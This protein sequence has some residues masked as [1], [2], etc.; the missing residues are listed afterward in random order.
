M[1]YKDIV[2]FVVVLL[3]ACGALSTIGGTINLIRGW[4]KESKITAH[5]KQIQDHENRIKALEVSKSTQEKYMKV[6]CNSV[7]ALVSHEINGN[8]IDKLKDAQEELKD[9]LI[10][11]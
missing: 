3:A 11:K 4:K 7:L 10:N 8:S 6:I 9:F 5:D 1:D 2:T